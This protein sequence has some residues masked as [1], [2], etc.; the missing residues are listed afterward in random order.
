MTISIEIDALLWDMQV[1]L[2]M[3]QGF[4][5]QYLLAMMP[6]LLT[7][8]D[9]AMSVEIQLTTGELN[10]HHIGKPKMLVP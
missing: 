9:A 7:I 2:R 5:E 1:C 6:I 4:F 8:N 3:A 10:H